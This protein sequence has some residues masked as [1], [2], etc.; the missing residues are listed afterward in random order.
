MRID[1]NYILSHRHKE[2]KVCG[3]DLLLKEFYKDFDYED[4]HMN[5]CKVCF[6]NSE[7]YI[8]NKLKKT[9]KKCHICKKVKEYSEF[10]KNDSRPDGLQ[11][12]CIECKNKTKLRHV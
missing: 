4:G 11:S 12:E 3:E 1:I 7:K 5:V 6:N 2:C 9:S 10:H 8:N